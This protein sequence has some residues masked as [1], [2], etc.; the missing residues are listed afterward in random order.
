MFGN[1]KPTCLWKHLKDEDRLNDKE[2][3]SI[4]S[5]IREIVI[6]SILGGLTDMKKD[7][8]KKRTSLYNCYKMLGWFKDKLQSQTLKHN[9]VLDT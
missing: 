2:L 4:W 8:K 6:L 7:F 1:Y 9:N 3:E 5:K